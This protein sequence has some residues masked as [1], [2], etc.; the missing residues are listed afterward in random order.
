MFYRSNLIRWALSAVVSI[1][2]SLVGADRASA[3]FGAAAAAGAAGGA[4]AAGAGGFGAGGFGVGG[5]N[6]A[7]MGLFG[8]GNAFPAASNFAG[9][10]Y[11]GMMNGYSGYGNGVGTGG[12]APGQAV[13]FG[14]AGRNPLIG[15]L[16]GNNAFGFNPNFNGFNP[17][18]NNPMGP[19]AFAHGPSVNSASLQA[20]FNNNPLM[21]N[22]SGTGVRGGPLNQTIF[23]N[24]TLGN[25]SGNSFA[26]FNTSAFPVYSPT[27]S[28]LASNNV[29]GFNPALNGFNYPYATSFINPYGINGLTPLNGFGPI[30][31]NGTM[32]SGRLLP[33]GAG[34]APFGVH[35]RNG[36]AIPNTAQELL[37]SNNFNFGSGNTFPVLPYFNP[38]VSMV[39][40]VQTGYG[41]GATS[42]PY[43]W[44]GGP[45]YSSFTYPGYGWSPY[46]NLMSRYTRYSMYGNRYNL[47]NGRAVTPYAA[48]TFY[49]PLALAAA[50]SESG[51]TSPLLTPKYPIRTRSTRRQ[52]V[53]PFRQPD[54]RDLLPRDQVLDQDGNIQWPSNAPDDSKDLAQERAAADRAVQIAATE[55]AEN[56]RAK[57]RDVVEARDKAEAYSRAAIDA[58]QD[59]NPEAANEM[60]LF[61][62]SLDRALVK[63]SEAPATVAAVTHIRPDNAPK[64]AGEVVR[65]AA[66]NDEDAKTPKPATVPDTN[67]AEP[68]PTPE[69]PTRAPRRSAGSVLNDASK[70]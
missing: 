34:A 67:Q 7:A 41:P 59:K 11:Q 12:L 16:A 44:A 23:S 27:I 26:G 17:V 68:A 37:G 43:R 13:S 3:Q 31:T 58:L 70:R 66:S 8:T 21:N 54:R 38:Y 51:S 55:A 69:I 50:L 18:I 64:T 42:W 4:G 5:G 9:S 35:F 63:L 48:S 36:I 15:N 40:P 2:L 39:G 61:A 57:V 47:R 19:N 45:Y 49:G 28:N 14:Q 32:T 52:G 1:G 53:V 25:L 22:L 6:A 65:D 46:A 24:P 56:G 29:V 60:A 10:G 20:Q 33:G 62:A 30:Y